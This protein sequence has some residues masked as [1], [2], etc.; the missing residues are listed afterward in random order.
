MCA[1]RGYASQ[2]ALLLLSHPLYFSLRVI[3]PASSAQLSPA[4]QA[5]QEG[6]HRSSLFEGASLQTRRNAPLP[7]LG[8][9]IGRCLGQHPTGD[10]GPACDTATERTLTATTRHQQLQWH[11]AFSP[12]EEDGFFPASPRTMDGGVRQRPEIQVSCHA[13]PILPTACRL[14]WP[15]IDGYLN[16]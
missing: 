8:P 11:L 4:T 14:G 5:G 2:R 1:P 7:V 13:L 3:L 9:S 15:G 6:G 10:R 16:G 12:H